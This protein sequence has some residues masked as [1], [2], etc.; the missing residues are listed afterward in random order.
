MSTDHIP[1]ETRSYEALR[2]A[3]PS[4]E[5]PSEAPSQMPP[6]TGRLLSAACVRVGRAAQRT[7]HS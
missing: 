5:R 2:Q 4:Q 1:H 6:L 7:Q 3:D